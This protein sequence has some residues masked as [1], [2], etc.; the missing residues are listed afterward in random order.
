MD[1]RFPFL[2]FSPSPCKSLIKTKLRTW[3]WHPPPTGT[4]RGWHLAQMERRGALPPSPT[5]CSTGNILINPPRF[6]K[7]EPLVILK[8]QS[9]SGFQGGE[10]VNYTGVGNVTNVTLKT[11]T[12]PVFSQCEGVVALG[13]WTLGWLILTQHSMLPSLLQGQGCL[14][15]ETAPASVTRVVEQL[16]L[17]E[18]GSLQESHRIATTALGPLSRQD[19]CYQPN[20][21]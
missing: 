5:F 7:T 19:H 16:G 1:L 9:N 21:W 4:R 10:R 12:G 2:H 8:V 20:L 14:F 6:S 15:K 3:V 11:K 17:Y 18:L 13:H